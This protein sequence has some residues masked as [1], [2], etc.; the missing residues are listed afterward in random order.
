MAAFNPFAACQRWYAISTGLALPF[1]R[2][3][4]LSEPADSGVE[5]AGSSGD[6][7]EGISVC[8]M[9][10]VLHPPRYPAALRCG[11]E[12]FAVS[13]QSSWLLYIKGWGCHL[14]LCLRMKSVLDWLWLYNGENV[15][16]SKNPPQNPSENK[17]SVPW[18]PGLGSNKLNQHDNLP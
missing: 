2:V 17:A 9:L 13:C 10:L 11:K 1:G 7:L 15:R 5:G 4:Q 12:C 8:P 18:L 6:K 16:F 14:V 3:R